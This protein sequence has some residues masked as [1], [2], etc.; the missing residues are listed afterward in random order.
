[1]SISKSR[2]CQS[3]NLNLN[4]VFRAGLHLDAGA[5]WLN[6][7]MYAMV[8]ISRT[9]LTNVNA[10]K[11]VIVFEFKFNFNMFIFK[12]NVFTTQYIKISMYIADV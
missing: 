2:A 8:V 1:M 7:E 11:I 12:I 9:L 6:R 5:Y 4:K 3:L 10:K